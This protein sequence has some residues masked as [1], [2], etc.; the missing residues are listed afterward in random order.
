MVVGRSVVLQALTLR[1]NERREYVAHS[2]PRIL[3]F[4]VCYWGT[5]VTGVG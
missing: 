1:T 4:K 5:R 2:M 3:L